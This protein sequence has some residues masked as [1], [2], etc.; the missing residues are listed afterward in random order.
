VPSRSKSLD[1]NTK[2]RA[3]DYP[4]GGTRR[5]RAFA[6]LH[7]PVDNILRNA[8][9][10]VAWSH[11]LGASALPRRVLDTPLC[12]FRDPSGAPSAL[13]DRCPHRF[14]PLSRG[15]VLSGMLQCGYHGLTFDA[16][17]QCIATARGGRVPS[18][19]A[20][21]AF[22]CYEQDA[23][24]W[25]WM[26]EA[27]EAETEK[28][29][30]FIYHLDPGFR[31]VT[32]T[33]RVAAHYELLTD[34]LLD[35][36]HTAYLHPAFGGADWQPHHRIQAVGDTIHSQYVIEDIEIPAFFAAMV[37]EGSMSRIVEWDDIRWNAPASMFLETR[38]GPAGSVIDNGFPVPSTHVLTPESA[39]LTRYFWASAVP[40]NSRLSDDDHRHFLREAFDNEDVPMIEAVHQSMNGAEFWSGRPLL[41]PADTAAVHARRRLS[42]LI[43]DERQSAA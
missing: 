39:A 43:A 35:L 10:M 6:N 41:L 1:C 11:E 18:A 4:S 40:A 17:G 33:S 42:K 7:S 14:A 20:V 12:V 32:G 24:I 36:S 31:V 5:E 9:Y 2:R 38:F 8:W 30:R 27:G 19:I 26:G 23:M 13:L 29:P 25:V 16:F 15:T 34:N 37:P 21:P 22:P 3:P 28:I